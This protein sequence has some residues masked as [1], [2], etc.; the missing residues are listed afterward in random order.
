MII[1]GIFG[2]VKRS[3]SRFLPRKLKM[4]YHEMRVLASQKPLAAVI[5]PNGRCPVFLRRGTTDFD[6]YIDVFIEEKDYGIDLPFTPQFIIDCGGNIG[7]AAVYFKMKYP[8]A[9]IVTIE[10]ATNNYELLLKNTAPF[11][12]IESIKAGV[13]SK[14]TKLIVK[15]YTGNDYEFVTEEAKPGDDLSSEN[16]VEAVGLEDVRLQRQKD[17]IDLLKIDIEGT[18]SEVFRTNYESWLSRTRAIVIEIHNHFRP[19]CSSVLNK[20]LEQFRFK[21]IRFEGDRQGCGVGF[22]LKE[23]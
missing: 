21:E 10:P 17:S 2:F 13:W 1:A 19:E 18:E 9:H 12:G 11:D 6:V 5:P 7:L 3:I 23:E 22:Y 15:N 20:A 8:D 14:S 16:C 4:I